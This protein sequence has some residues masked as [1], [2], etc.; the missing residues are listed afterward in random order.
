[1]SGV[2]EACTVTGARA[3]AVMI[4]ARAVNTTMPMASGLF[5]KKAEA[6]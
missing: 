1:M 6:C 2:T 4:V 3:R 5:I